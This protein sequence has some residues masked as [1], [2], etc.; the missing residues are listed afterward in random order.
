MFDSTVDEKPHLIVG[1]EGEGDFENVL[2][3]AGSVAGDLAPEGEPVDLVRVVRGE[4]GIGKY[5]IEAA[6][7]FYKRD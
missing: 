6:K 4:A 7:P 3:E 5:F 1:I 2:R